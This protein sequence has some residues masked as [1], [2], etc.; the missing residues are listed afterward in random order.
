VRKLCVSLVVSGL[1]G[2]TSGCGSGGPRPGHEPPQGDVRLAKDAD[3]VEARVP[4]NATLETLLRQE[5]LPADMTAS[6]VDAVRAVFNPRELRADRTYQITRT[7]DGLFREFTYQIDADR[8]LRVVSL[9]P[10][11]DS[12][13]RFDA[14]IVPLPKDLEDAAFEAEI[15]REHS[16]LIGAFNAG[17][18]NIQLAL[19]LA[20][21]FGGEVDFNSELQLGDR[22][23]VL[24][25]RATRNGEFIGYGEIKA[26][27]L[28]TG[29]RRL[30]AI[31]HVGPDGKPG[32]FNEAGRSL[33]RQF[34]RSPLPFEPRITS[35]FSYN[36]LHPV[37]GYRRPHLGVDY[38]AP[39]GTRV[40]AVA[41][42]VVESA[43]WAGEA[44]RMVKIRHAGGYETAYLH[45]SAFAPDIRPGVRVAQGD[46]IGRV[47][48][49]GT[50]TGPHLDYRIIK[51]GRY[52]NPTAELAKMPPGEP[53][54][55]DRLAMF[56]HDRDDLLGELRSRLATLTPAPSP[57]PG[58]SPGAPH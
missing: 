52:V 41:A 39:A 24:F 29:G 16:S 25:E 14:E 40:N 47:G 18:E 1:V 53:I 42:G 11:D 49:S 20:D 37:L 57:A 2:L 46:F 17:G 9:G 10:A 28:D 12:T 15:S 26:A 43:G 48:Q 44:G 22:F 27:V 58:L 4:P 21:I 33:K 56:V 54:A 30:V 32:W 34:L 7:L 36:R 23:E 51:N 45:L 55:S 19:S 3:I 8:L 6:M 35:R 31:R 50:A 38:G 13:P 5:H